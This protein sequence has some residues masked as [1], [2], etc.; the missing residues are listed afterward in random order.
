MSSIIPIQLAVEDYL[1]ETVLHT[2]L[3]KSEHDFKVGACYGR[4]GS[5]Y[6]KKRIRGFNNAARGTPFLV[7]TDLNSTECAPILIRD[8]LPVPRHNNLIFRIAVREVESW[9][10]ADRASFA[11]FF[12]IRI[13]IVTNL[14][15][16]LPDPKKYLLELVSRSPKR[17]LKRAI[18]PADESTAKIGPDYN[19][20]LSRFVRN[21]WNVDEAAKVSPS[22]SCAIDAIKSFRPI[23]SQ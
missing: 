18:I 14:P 21:K 22:L 8:W 13:S 20:V 16:E 17:E 5:A 10:M 12:G 3:F 15:D 9:L 6:L 11:R 23:Y 1:G 2:L 7:L 19:G 4:T